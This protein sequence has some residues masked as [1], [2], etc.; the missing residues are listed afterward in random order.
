MRSLGAGA[1]L[2]RRV[3]GVDFAA[4]ELVSEWAAEANRCAGL[5]STAGA[6]GIVVRNPSRSAPATRIVARN[7]RIE[8]EEEEVEAGPDGTE[9]VIATRSSPEMDAVAVAVGR[10]VDGMEVVEKIAGVG[11]VRDNNGSPYF[12]FLNSFAFIYLFYFVSR[13]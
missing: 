6:V 10:V 11:A 1:D 9:F 4:G 3:S 8:V 2:A 13:W 5:R 7:G 12:R